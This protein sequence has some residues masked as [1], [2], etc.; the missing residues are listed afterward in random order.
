MAQAMDRLLEGCLGT[1]LP[2]PIQWWDGSVS[3]PTEGSA[4]ILVRSPRGLRRILYSPNQLGVVR[5]YVA[6]ELDIEGDIFEILAA[7]NVLATDD[8]PVRINLG[9][10]QILSGV[11]A[12]ARVG[13]L[14]APLSPP[15][16]EVQ[17]R[18]RKHSVGRDRKAISHHYDLS[19]AFYRLILG[20]TM[21]YSCAY[22]ARREMSLDDAQRNKH[23]VVCRKLGLQ[24]GM[25]LLDVGCGWGGLV[26]HAAQNYGVQAVGVT[27]SAAQHDLASKRIE[28]A[29]LAD[30]V[31]IR[32][33][34]YREVDDGPYDAIASVGM[35]EHV[36]SSKSE[37]Y[38][39]NLLGLLSAEGR[40][41]NHA[42]SAPVDRDAAKGSALILRYVFPDGELQEVGSVVT[43]MQ[44]LGFEVRDVESLRE[45]YGLTL[46]A[47]LENLENDW[48]AAVAAAGISRAR[49][50]KL[51]MAAAALTFESGRR[52]VYQVL[53]VKPTPYGRSG[54]P[55]SRGELLGVGA[56]PR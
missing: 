33:Q 54:M 45:H 3:N 56:P 7:R 1:R 53:G 34:D 20:D 17:L 39:R 55:L 24:P 13:A 26:L 42:I 35:F 21:T 19:N 43:R 16:E 25:R 4:R 23:D 48:D 30:R 18:G 41:L 47:W 37:E 8:A 51:Y 10:R 44:A 49:I 52:S 22:F 38:F 50:W 32:V 31:E 12:L 36:G 40:F 6:G 27:L 11:Y 46:R 2:V 15:P 9:I 14:G 5:A 28:A 29:G